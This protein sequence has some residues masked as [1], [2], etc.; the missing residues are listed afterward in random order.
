M[1]CSSHYTAPLV[2]SGDTTVF[3]SLYRPLGVFSSY[4]TNPLVFSGTTT[5]FK[6]LYRPPSVFR[7]R[8]SFQVIIQTSWFFSWDTM[9]CLSHR[10]DLLVF[11]ETTMAC[12]SH[13][14]DLLLF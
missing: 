13:Y 14:I 1:A 8:N 4:Y 11:L 10:T 5:V 2:F 12:S 7:D 6:S 3:R 9:G